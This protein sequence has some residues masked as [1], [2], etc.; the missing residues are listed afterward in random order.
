VKEF[1]YKQFE[2][3]AKKEFTPDTF[4]FQLKGRVNFSPGQFVQIALDHFG[5]GTYAICSDPE[6]KK[7]FELCIRGCGNLSNRLIEMVPGDFLKLRGPFGKGWPMGKLLENNLVIIAGGMGLVPLRP[8]LFSMI[9]YRKNFKKISIVLGFRSDQHI[10]F[11]VNIEA[12]R[13]NKE[14]D[15]FIGVA[16]HA[17]SRFWGSKGLITDG[18]KKIKVD[19]K[20]IALI[21]GP[22]VMVPYCTDFL[23][24]Q[25]VEE[26]NI[27]ISY[28][29]RMECGIGVCQHCNV[30]KYMVCK[31][32]PVFSYEKIKNELT[33]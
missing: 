32:G 8:L 18:L 27:Y 23:I 14:I 22:D 25:K 3:I 7:Y 4:L 31:D 21:C 33:K 2:I 12:L 9:K 26:K 20:S 16:E 24:N 30:G 29:R 10:L 1:D 17:D 19:K 11:P 13:Q 5:E 6:D 15:Q 28:E